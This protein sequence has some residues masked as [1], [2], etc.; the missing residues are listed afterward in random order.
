LNWK[1]RSAR[2]KRVA[3]VGYLFDRNEGDHQG[4]VAE[5]KRLLTAFGVKTSTV[6]L[7]GTPFEKLKRLPVPDLIVDLAGDWDGGRR[8]AREYGTGYLACGLPVGLEGTAAWIRRIA[9][10]LDLTKPAEKLVDRELSA[11]VP[12]LQWLLPR[13][14]Q[15]RS[16]LVFADR[17]RVGPL[18]RFLEELGMVI[19]GVGCT[20]TGSDELPWPQV[21]LQIPALRNFL[22]EAEVSGRADLIVGNSVIRQVARDFRV[23]FVELGYPSNFHHC[24]HPAP[25]L[26]YTGA[27]VLVERMINAILECGGPACG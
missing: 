18:A 6:L 14:F 12:R 27:R 23:P 11:L 8:L 19:T 2:A 26:G 3:L 16:A 25:F 21:P 4:N 20:S 1:R 10:A 5:L 9:K 7:D 15:G 17:L 13:F 22:A 24:L